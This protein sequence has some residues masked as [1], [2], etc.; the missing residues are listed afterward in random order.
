V[1]GLVSHVDSARL[2][3]G[4][5]SLTV[6]NRENCVA[7]TLPPDAPDKISSTIALQLAGPVAVTNAPVLQNSDGSVALTA[8]DGTLHGG[9]FRYEN[10]GPLDN[11]GYWTNPEDW[12][13]WEFQMQRPGKF[14]ISATIAAPA[15]TSFEVSVEGQ[16][17]QF[18][19]PVTADFMTFKPVKL[20]VID[21]PATGKIKLAVR[22]VKNGWQPM[23][24][25]EVRLT[26]AHAD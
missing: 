2:L 20:G 6:E 19:S 23:N 12:V 24:L 7:I 11:I 8:G 5:K 21:I 14:E 4:G 26:Q 16:R 18:A 10:G 13:D 9:T 17:F 3:N 1:P 22:P 25:K 15:L